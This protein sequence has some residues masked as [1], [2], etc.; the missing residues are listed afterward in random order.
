MGV[1]LAK[2]KPEITPTQQIENIEIEPLFE[3]KTNL[4]KKLGLQRER[5]LNIMAEI[6]KNSNDIEDDYMMLRYFG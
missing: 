6:L 2:N 3:L 4:L 5:T 1:L